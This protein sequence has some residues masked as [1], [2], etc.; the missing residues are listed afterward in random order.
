MPTFPPPPP[1]RREGA[2][3]VRKNVLTIRDY[4]D[5]L[6]YEDKIYVAD[7]RKGLFISVFNE[8]GNPLYEISHKIPSIKVPD[9][10]RDPSGRKYDDVT[11]EFFPA[12]INFRIDADRI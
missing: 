2:S 8:Q 12:F 11:R 9:D 7:S 1:S 6:V 5:L 3:A 10:L 4:A